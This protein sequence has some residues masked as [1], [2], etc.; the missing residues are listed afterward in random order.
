MR[1]IRFLY[2]F[3][4][5]VKVMLAARKPNIV[6]ILVDD[7]GWNDVSWHNTELV[8]PNLDAMA[9]SSLIL[10]QA[11]SQP[12]CSCSCIGQVAPWI[13]QFRISSHKQRV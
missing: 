8:M 13:L 1:Q 4:Y 5:C 10:E 7:L 12:T 9:R 3:L 6:F 11:Y 2:V